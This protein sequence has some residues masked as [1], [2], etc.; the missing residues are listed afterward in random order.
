MNQALQKKSRLKIHWKMRLKKFN[1]L[2]IKSQPYLKN[3]IIHT[4]IILSLVHVSLL[5]FT[6][7]FYFVFLFRIKKEWGREWKEKLLIATEI[8]FFV[9]EQVNKPVSLFTCISHFL[10]ISPVRICCS[11]YIYLFLFICSL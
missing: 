1:I 8:E 5:Y 3:K 2:I 11:Q 7:C 4:R 10:F 6:H 9:Y